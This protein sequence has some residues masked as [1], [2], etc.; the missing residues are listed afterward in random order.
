MNPHPPS[1][2]PTDAPF[3]RDCDDPENTEP[4]ALTNSAP[5]RGFWA[6]GELSP[7]FMIPPPWNFSAASPSPRQDF[8]IV[9]QFLFYVG[10]GEMTL[11][12]ADAVVAAVTRYKLNKFGLV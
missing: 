3:R 2:T 11:D 12:E 1:A 7:P 4:Q 5:D 6:Q 9:Q 10:S 8:T